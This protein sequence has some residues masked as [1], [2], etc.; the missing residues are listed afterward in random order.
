MGVTTAGEDTTL[1]NHR[2]PGGEPEDLNDLYYRYFEIQEAVTSD[3]TRISQQVRYQVYCV[4][5]AYEDAAKSQS[6]LETDEYDGHAG[7]AVLFHRPT[8]LPAGTVRMVVPNYDDLDHSFALQAYCNDPVIR[9]RK[10][11]PVERMGEISRFSVPKDFRR[12]AEDRMFNHFPNNS[13]L[14]E[15]EHRRVIPNMTL[16]LIEWLVRFSVREGLTHWCAVTE[17]RLLRLLGRLGIHFN[18]IGDLVEFHGLR[19]PC[20]IELETLLRRTRDERPDVWSLITANGAHEEA[21][22]AQRS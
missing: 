16:G 7:T 22:R 3:L 1:E 20:F 10:R 17:P 18:P 13:E 6:G 9:D 19:Q 2:M 21:L 15:G 12:R 8:G 4:E 14:G 11:F 5:N